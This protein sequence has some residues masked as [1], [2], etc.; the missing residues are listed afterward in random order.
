[1]I[2]MFIA[3]FLCGMVFITVFSVMMHR[4][5]DETVDD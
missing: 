4:D 3:G 1:M 2:L 5:D